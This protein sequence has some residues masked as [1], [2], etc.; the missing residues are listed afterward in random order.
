MKVFA[1]HRHE[2]AT[3]IHVS[4]D[5]EPRSNLP[6]HPV[7]P[8]CP[9]ALALGALFHASNLALVIY[10]TYGNIHV[11]VL[12]SQIIPPSPS[13]RVQKSILYICVS[14]AALHVGSLLLS[15]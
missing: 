4:P 2:S 12:F 9:R 15:F 10:F 14:F 3:G 1:I 8:G 5:P 11:P 13:P 7:P 6:P